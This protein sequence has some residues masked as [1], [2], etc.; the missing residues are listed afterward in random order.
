MSRGPT[1]LQAEAAA[2]FLDLGVRLPLRIDD[3][4]PRLIVDA[5]GMPVAMALPTPSLPTDAGRA[6][7]LAMLP[8]VAAGIPEPS[9]TAPLDPHHLAAV[10]A[11][12][13]QQAGRRGDGSR[14][15]AAE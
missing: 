2:R 4:N 13:R 11:E 1:A 7:L 8:N 14:K 15:Q 10:K 9:L 5:D 6:V 12:S 3:R